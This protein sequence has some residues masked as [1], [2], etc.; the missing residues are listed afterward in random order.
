MP[1]AVDARSIRLQLGQ[2]GDGMMLMA[3]SKP[4]LS[5]QLV[6]AAAVAV[7]AQESTPWIGSVMSVPAGVVIGL[8]GSAENVLA[9]VEKFAV[10]LESRTPAEV[11]LGA[12]PM[13][14]S[15]MWMWPAKLMDESVNAWMVHLTSRLD[16]DRLVDVRDLGAWFDAP[17]PDPVPEAL[18]RRDFAGSF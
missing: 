10:Q 9:F 4:V 18:A 7:A 13:E 15:P 11:R 1:I 5:A 2:F 12:A 3:R 14:S 8:Q 6:R 17:L 16:G